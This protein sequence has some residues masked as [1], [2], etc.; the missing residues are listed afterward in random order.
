[1]KG[2]HIMRWNEVIRT[3]YDL[4]DYSIQ[5]DDKKYNIYVKKTV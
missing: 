1:M 5:K 4:F 2:P 3:N